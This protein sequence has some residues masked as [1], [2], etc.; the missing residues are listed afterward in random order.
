MIL[1]H[2]DKEKPKETFISEKLKSFKEF[3]PVD[4]HPDNVI[5]FENN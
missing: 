3:G 4:I 1:T 2:C 5:L